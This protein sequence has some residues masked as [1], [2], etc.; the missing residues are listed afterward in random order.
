MN[1]AVVGGSH[2]VSD[3][4][5]VGQSELATLMRAYDWT[6][7]PL[8]PPHTWPAALK[9][10]VRIMLSSR[11]PIWIGWG[12]ELTYLYNDPYRRSS[13]TSIHGCSAS[14]PVSCGRRSGT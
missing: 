8:G 9:I 1:D 11:Q 3:Q 2:T 5:I 12:P 7:T 6:K 14:R 13:A 10:S 4:P